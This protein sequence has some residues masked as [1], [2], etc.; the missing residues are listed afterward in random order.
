MLFMGKNYS[1]HNIS[2]LLQ[3]LCFEIIILDIYDNLNLSLDIIV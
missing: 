2:R 1:I 3:L